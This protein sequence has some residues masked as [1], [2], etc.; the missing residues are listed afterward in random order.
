[1]SCTVSSHL[2]RKSSESTGVSSF[3]PVSSTQSESASSDTSTASP[4]SST[5][6]IAV[7]AMAPTHRTAK[8]VF[9]TF[10]DST[11][12]EGNVGWSERASPAFVALTGLLL[13]QFTIT[14]FDASVRSFSLLCLLAVADLF[15]FSHPTSSF[16]PRP[17]HSS[18]S[19]LPIAGSHG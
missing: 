15:S 13:T 3:L 14:G 11:G 10:N 6:G 4:S 16:P 18:R 19:T 7:L 5:L 12:A 17:P 9:A 1:V 2:H 8:E